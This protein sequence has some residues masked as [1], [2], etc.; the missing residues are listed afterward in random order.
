MAARGIEGGADI[1]CLAPLC[2]APCVLGQQ[3]NHERA[4]RG[5]ASGAPKGPTG[6]GGGF[7][8]GNSGGGG[9]DS[10]GPSSRVGDAFF[11]AAAWM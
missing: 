10:G 6:D 4:L 1:S 8:G 5:G 3:L 7:T 2:C 9:G 11:R